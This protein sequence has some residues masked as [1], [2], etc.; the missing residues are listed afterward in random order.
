M[1]KR[2]E[3]LLHLFD[4]VW[5]DIGSTIK[6]IWQSIVILLGAI[7]TIIFTKAN[8][9]PITTAYSIIMIAIVWILAHVE[10]AA[11]WFN[12]NLVIIAN[13]ERQFLNEDDS[14]QIHCYFLG[15]RPAKM[16][17]HF[18]LQ[19]WF[20]IA[21]AVCLLFY[22]TTT[23]IFPFFKNFP[24]PSYC[25]YI[26]SV[27]YFP[28]LLAVAGGVLLY[29]F[30]NKNIEKYNEFKMFSPGKLINKKIDFKHGHGGEALS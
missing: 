25:Y 26:F 29:V 1:D 10:N 6:V 2:E 4:K 30:K 12:R 3:F 11:Y 8:I 15:H 16:A 13:I 7:A 17:P 28:Y 5:D 19:Y 20:L 22:Y 21:I 27:V 23:K 18:Q 24:Q 9:V 14:E